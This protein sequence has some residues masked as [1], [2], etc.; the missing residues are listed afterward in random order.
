MCIN[1]I[2]CLPSLPSPL[3]FKQHTVGAKVPKAPGRRWWR[4]PVQRAQLLLGHDVRLVPMN[5]LHHYRNIMGIS[6]EYHGNSQFKSIR[7]HII[8]MSWED[9]Q[10]NSNGILLDI[11]NDNHQSIVHYI[12][13]YPLVHWCIVPSCLLYPCE[14]SLQ[15]WRTLVAIRLWF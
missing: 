14:G 13:L 8:K 11:P 15:R 9:H 5:D 4:K 7:Q 3:L 12:I 6:W 2:Q 10:W 1:F